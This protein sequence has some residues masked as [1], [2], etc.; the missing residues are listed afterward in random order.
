VVDDVPVHLLVDCFDFAARGGVD[1]IEQRRERIAQTEAA[2]ASVTDVKHALEL[3][4]QRLLVQVV[5]MAP[6]D[7][8]TRRRFQAAFTGT[9]RRV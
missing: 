2:A 1:R 9:E 3:A 4:E 8:M 7:R 6:F 5:G